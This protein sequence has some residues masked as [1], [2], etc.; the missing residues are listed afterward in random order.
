[1]KK[2]SN[3]MEINDTKCEVYAIDPNGTNGYDIVDGSEKNLTDVTYSLSS[4]LYADYIAS[5]YGQ[6]INWEDERVQSI[7]Q[8]KPWEDVCDPFA[9]AVDIT[10]IGVVVVQ[11]IGN[12]GLIFLPDINRAQ[13]S[14]LASLIATMEDF[15]FSLWYSDNIIDNISQSVLMSVLSELENS[16]LLK[17]QVVPSIIERIL[18]YKNSYNS[19]TTEESALTSGFE[20]LLNMKKMKKTK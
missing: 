3:T 13:L 4:K 19:K 17:G 14:G 11:F 12:E 10:L 7:E 9:A 1:M 20:L 2:I 5:L 15:N 18:S 6:K 8:E 16:V